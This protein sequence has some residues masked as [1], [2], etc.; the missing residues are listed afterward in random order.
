MS[1]GG[2]DRAYLHALFGFRIW[3][4]ESNTARYPQEQKTLPNLILSALDPL[5][6][7]SRPWLSPQAVAMLG[8][9]AHNPIGVRTFRNSKGGAVRV[10]Y[11][12][13]E[14]KGSEPARVFKDPLSRIVEGYLHVFAGGFLGPRMRKGG[15]LFEFVSLLVRIVVFFLPLSRAK[16]P[17]TYE[18]LPPKLEAGAKTAP[19]IM[20]SHGL[21]G[22]SDEH[23]FL[24]ASL[25]SDGNIVALVHHTDGSSARAEHYNE[26]EEAGAVSKALYYQHPPP[27][28]DYD[29]TYRPRQIE[30]RASEIEDSRKALMEGACGQDLASLVDPARMV[31]GGFSFGAATA[32]YVAA[33][34]PKVREV[35]SGG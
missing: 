19:L 26:K 15:L 31:I 18:S 16:I 32:S 35:T 28:S 5:M 6:I 9:A 11:P 30:R 1:K 17:Q 13:V 34:Q 8:G 14:E 20:W 3:E 2:V 23:S 29:P 25:A 12:G 21:T 10:F 7:I 24:A 22:T 27:P 33:T 4:P